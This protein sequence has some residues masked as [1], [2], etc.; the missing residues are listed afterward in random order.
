MLAATGL[1]NVQ[2]SDIRF[3]ING[4]TFSPESGLFD[5]M[6]PAPTYVG[7]EQININLKDRLVKEALY[8]PLR[9]Q[10]VSASGV[11]IAPSNEITIQPLK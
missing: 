10:I 9:I 11:E 7:Y 6:G 4:Q 8:Q 1:A 2:L 5:W 3:V